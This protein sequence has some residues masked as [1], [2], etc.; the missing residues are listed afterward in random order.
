MGAWTILYFNT[1]VYFKYMRK[2]CYYSLGL[3]EFFDYNRSSHKNL[4]IKG[5]KNIKNDWEF[6]CIY[7][8]LVFRSKMIIFIHI[9]S[10]YE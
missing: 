8:Y 2:Y 10:L 3:F 7:N 4:S 9:T 5:G 6:D 1:I